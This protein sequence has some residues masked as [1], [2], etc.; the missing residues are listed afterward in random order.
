MP[1]SATHFI[2]AD[3]VARS[4]GDSRLG[5]ACRQAP[6][7]LRLG[8]IFHDLLYYPAGLSTPDW[9]AAIPRAL[10]GDHGEDTLAAAKGLLVRTVVTAPELALAVGIASHVHADAV[11]HPLVNHLAV[12][13]E[14]CAE[15]ERARALGRHYL[16]EAVMDVHFAGWAGLDE[17][18]VAPVLFGLE[19]DPEALLAAGLAGVPGVEDPKRAGLVMARSARTMAVLNR[20]FLVRWV[21]AA[22]HRIKAV[23]PGKAGA[24]ANLFYAPKLRGCTAKLDGRIA[25]RHPVTGEE[26]AAGL[27]GLA[28]RAVAECAAWCAS[29]DEQG[30]SSVGAL[31]PGPQLDTGLVGVDMADARYWAKEPFGC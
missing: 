24:Y 2:L 28:E 8:S 20:L 18:A 13:R 25:Y 16:L 11:F 5:M 4:L 3:R 17:R 10:H 27:D 7:A 31:P 29:I 15:H 6:N 19:E 12:C 9:A 30:P 1:S 26:R 14:G 21:A 22:M 23:L